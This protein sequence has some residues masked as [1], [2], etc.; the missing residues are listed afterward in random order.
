M[1]NLT[2]FLAAFSMFTLG[3][4]AQAHDGDSRVDIVFEGDVMPIVKAGAVDLQFELLDTKTKKLVAPADLIITHEKILHLFTFDPALNE[5]RHEHPEYVNGKWNVRLQIPVNGK[6]WVYAQGRVKADG[7]V[8][9][10]GGSRFLVKDGTPENV[11]PPDLRENRKGADGNSIVALSDDALRAKA[12]AMLIVK[13]S[14]V[15]GTKPVITPW[16]GAKAHVV[17]TPDDGDVL[18]HVHPMEMGGQLMIHATFPNAGAYRIW[19]QF[20]DGGVL[21][22]VPLAVSVSN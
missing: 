22:T 2:T 19:V 10:A 17:A 20:I 1:K 11:S 9:F 8:D 18:L 3:G 13:F 4:I 21:R 7:G 15:D 6:Y 14:R 5:F 16:L 12:M